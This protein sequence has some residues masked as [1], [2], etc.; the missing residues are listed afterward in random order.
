MR[1]DIIMNNV[2]AVHAVDV[3]WPMSLSP[4]RT[5]L[6]CVMPVTAVSFPPNVWPATK[7]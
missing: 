2:S 4:V 1:T 3:H 6:S 7:L 5:M